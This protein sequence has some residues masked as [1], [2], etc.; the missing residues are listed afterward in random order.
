VKPLINL[1]KLWYISRRGNDICTVAVSA[2]ALQSVMGAIIT[3][4][5]EAD[6]NLVKK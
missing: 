2:K 3:A 4:L 1:Q 5:A 6:R